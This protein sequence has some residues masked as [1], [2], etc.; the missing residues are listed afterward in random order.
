[1]AIKPEHHLP[2]MPRTGRPRADE[3]QNRRPV[4]RHEKRPPD[5]E[6]PRFQ[7]FAGGDVKGVHLHAAA[8]FGDVDLERQRAGGGRDVG[9][10][11]DL[12]LGLLLDYI[13]FRHGRAGSAKPPGTPS[14]PHL[15]F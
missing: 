3:Q 10:A 13:S 12:N 6:P 11:L 4:P 1:M 7:R 8:V 14:C 5:G 9:H 15:H 2:S